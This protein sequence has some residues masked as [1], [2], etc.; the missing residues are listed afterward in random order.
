VHSF[1]REFVVV[2][3]VASLLITILLVAGIVWYGKRRPIGAPLT[4][5]EAMLAGTYCF[6]LA[7]LAYGIVPHQWLLL[8]ENEW[9]WRADRIVVGPGNVLEPIA[10][11]GWVPFTLT[12]RVLG[13]SVAVLIYVIALAVHVWLFAYWQ[14]RAKA[15]PAAAPVRSAYGRPLVKRG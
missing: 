2:A 3:L 4:W 6:M 8:A 13:D 1:T 15:R 14:D 11:G 5:A 12:Y 10:L 7:F 9:S